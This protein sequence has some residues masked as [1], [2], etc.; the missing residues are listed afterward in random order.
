M[1]S[2]TYEEIR[3]EAAVVGINCTVAEAVPSAVNGN[4]H[5]LLLLL[6]GAQAA[7]LAEKWTGTVQCIW[8][9]AYRPNHRRK[10][11]YVGVKSFAPF[12]KE[13][14]KLSDISFETARASGPGGQH[15]NKTQS[16]VRAVHIPT[17][18]SVMA[19]DERSQARNKTLALARL[20]YLLEQG[21]KQAE[22]DAKSARRLQHY[23]LERG[24]LHVTKIISFRHPR[25]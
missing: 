11:W 2:R 15:V 4:Y 23:K 18:K 7:Q 16:A 12:S 8:R 13:D 9:S 25:A 3:A 6:E 22:N 5:S 19:Q 14:F 20:M 10:N 24:S 21:T 17:G 1:V